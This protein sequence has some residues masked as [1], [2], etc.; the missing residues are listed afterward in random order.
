LPDNKSFK[1]MRLCLYKKPHGGTKN[2]VEIQLASFGKLTQET[3]P[4]GS[5]SG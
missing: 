1:A 5:R 4:A 2:D 3:V